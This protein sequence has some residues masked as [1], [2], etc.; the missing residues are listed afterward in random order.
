MIIFPQSSTPA[1]HAFHLVVSAYSVS[2]FFLGGWSGRHT[3]QD[4]R[5]LHIRLT[6]DSAGSG[7]L[8]GR[9]DGTLAYFGHTLGFPRT[10]FRRSLPEDQAS[11]RPSSPPPSPSTYLFKVSVISHTRL[12]CPLLSITGSQRWGRLCHAFT[13]WCAVRCNVCQPAWLP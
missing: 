2:V 5:R 13:R 8:Q 12:P 11:S 3:I 6:H 4:T 1:E 10:R 7:T 9:I